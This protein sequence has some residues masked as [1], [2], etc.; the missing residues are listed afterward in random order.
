[1]K[2][3]EKSRIRTLQLERINVQKKTFTKWCNSFLSKVSILC[4]SKKWELTILSS[5]VNL[6]FFFCKIGMEIDDLFRD[7]QDGR[8]LIKLLEMISGEKLG[9]PN[10]GKLK[11]H[12][13]ENVNRA[14]I[15]IQSKQK[16]ESI[17][18]EDIVAGNPT[19]ILGLIWTIIL[20]FQIQDIEIEL[21]NE[22]KDKRSAK[23]ALLLWCQR[24][25]NNYPNVRV[26]DFT[27]SWR[28][29]LAFNALVHSQRPD[30]FDFTSLDPNEHQFNLNHAFEMAQRHLDISKLLD[31]EDIDVDKPDEKSIL[32]YVSSYFHT[33][34]KL[35]TEAVGGKRVGKIIGFLMD[36]ERMIASYET[37][38]ADLLQW[39]QTKI[40]KHSE[41]TF[42][43]SLDAIKALKLTFTKEYRELEK[44][45]RLKS[46]NELPGILHEI[47]IQLVSQQRA[48]YQ[49]AEGLT[50]YDVEVAWTRLEKA[51]RER[52]LALKKELNRQELLEQ[53]YGKFDKK[54]KLREDWLNDMAS[55]L[56]QSLMADTAQIEATCRKQEAIGTDMRARA[57]RFVR[58]DQLA[59]NLIDEDYFYK[60]SVKK[61]NTQIQFTYTSLLEQF[62][63]RQATL[64]TF[65]ELESLF[66]EMERLKNEMLELEKA[67]Q[68]RDYGEYLLAADELIAK[69]TLLEAQRAV[70]N[71]HL[72]SINR[73]AQ[74][75]TRGVQENPPPDHHTKSTLQK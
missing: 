30:L 50:L 25:T 61:R 19:L 38:V 54:A 67:F 16:L 24:K 1:M 48:K 17:G 70:I 32:T 45:P 2:D 34:A 42:P 23:E 64:N 62:E 52:E 14:L 57:D 72:K 21:E 8:R 11:V 33:F 10:Q 35:K 66:G 69:H 18:A 73:R 71:Q 43:N 12:K 47:N 53:M 40:G 56:S 65:Q 9:K 36:S 4:Y 49:P 63:R 51:E 41:H 20:R 44:K 37:Q 55:V 22:S 7:L 29:G 5:F 3:F 15:F 75:F 26:T 28:N 27:N 74:Q 31:P 39:T 60:E 13:I 58:L 6:I 46:K 68:S 59:Q